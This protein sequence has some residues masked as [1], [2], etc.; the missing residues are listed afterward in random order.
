[1]VKLKWTEQAV[2]DLK[3][4]FDYIS[5]DSIYYAKRQISKIKLSVDPL[6][7]MPKLGRVVPEVHHTS[8]DRIEVS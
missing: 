3:N 8:K 4:I 1:M 6:K 5:N 7:I 2:G